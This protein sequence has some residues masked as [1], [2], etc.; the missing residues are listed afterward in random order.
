MDQWVSQLRK[1]LVEFCL[2]KALLQGE[3]YGYRLVQRLRTIEGLA[4]TES[5]VYP[6]LSRLIAEGLVGATEKPSSQG[7]P[8]RYLRLTAKGKHRL[9]QMETHW[10]QTCR[11]LQSLDA[12]GLAE[13][14][15]V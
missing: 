7:P 8:R 11:D 5:T 3:T 10:Q 15:D 2:L 1:G 6:A 13:D 4:F 14:E 9:T 12:E